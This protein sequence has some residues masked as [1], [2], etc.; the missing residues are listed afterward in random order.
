MTVKHSLLLPLLVLL[1]QPHGLFAA[2]VDSLAFNQGR[3]RIWCETARFIYEDNGADS[4]L[5]SI[6]CQSIE[7]LKTS[8]ASTDE[9]LGAL[10]LLNSVDKPAIYAGFTSTEASLQKLVTEVV[11]RLKSSPVRRADPARLSSVD[12]LQQQLMLVALQTGVPANDDYAE[13]ASP[14][15]EGEEEEAALLAVNNVEEDEAAAAL[16]WNE[17]LQWLAILLIGGFAIWRLLD[18]QGKYDRMKKDQRVLERQVNEFFYSNLQLGNQ[19]ASRQES[20][21]EK[22][23]RQ[24]VKEELQHNRPASRQQPARE[25]NET[26]LPPPPVPDVAERH[27][28]KSAASPVPSSDPSVPRPEASSQSSLRNTPAAEVKADS[29]RAAATDRAREGAALFY[30][31]MP[32][33]GGFHQNEM[34]RERLRDSLYTIQLVPQQPGEA[35]YWITEDTEVQR[36]AMQNGLSFFEEGCEF[37]EVEENPARVV[38]E[39]KGRL[40]KEGQ[41]WKILQKAKVRFE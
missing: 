34:S 10:R 26:P 7:T 37:T 18:L 22:D 3:T 21:S 12:S 38:N 41:V 25:V 24:V 35:D 8:I 9:R 16:P 6:N 27:S 19:P 14:G 40:R 15:R 33:K 29:E 2:Q 28:A 30:D 11:A 17:I 32:F 13:T 36:Y 20:L 5:A 23:V 31:K 39:R 1:L 4:L